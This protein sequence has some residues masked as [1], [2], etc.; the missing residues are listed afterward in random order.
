MPPV[1]QTAWPESTHG[2]LLP[3]N[4]PLTI[5]WPPPALLTV[6]VTGTLTG[7]LV[8]PV[9]VTVIAPLYVPGVRPAMLTETVTAEGA[10]P[11]V[12]LT[13]SHVALSVALQFN[14]P[15]PVLVM[16]RDWFAGFAPPAVA[17]KLKLDGLT[18]IVG[19]VGAPALP[20]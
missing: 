11:E 14:V 12:G 19:L 1:D 6:R 9:A 8:A 13:L 15:P 4:P 7:E 10:V 18:P 5:N 16:P 2:L 17:V 3:S 20:L